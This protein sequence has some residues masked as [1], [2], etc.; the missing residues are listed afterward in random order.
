[1]LSPVFCDIRPTVPGPIEPPKSPAIAR[2]AN[3]AVPPAGN[4][5]DVMLK[6]PGHMMPTEKP[7][8][9]HPINAIMGFLKSEASM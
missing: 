1:M 3:I 9:I 4:F 5:F 8:I 2:S 7:H 6:V